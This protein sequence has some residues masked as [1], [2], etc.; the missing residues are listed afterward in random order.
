MNWNTYW[1]YMTINTINIYPRYNGKLLSS[2]SKLQTD[3]VCIDLP[4]QSNIYGA[5]G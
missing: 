3:I 2:L 5:I 1:Y 4:K